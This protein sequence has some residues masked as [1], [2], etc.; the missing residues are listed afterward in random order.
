MLCFAGKV[1][2]IIF[3]MMSLVF[4]YL[5]TIVTLGI[6]L[7]PLTPILTAETFLNN[8]HTTQSS[9]SQHPFLDDSFYIKWSSLKPACIEGDIEAAILL[10][11]K[12]I[13]AI[14]NT[15][16][17]SLTFENTLLALEESMEKLHRAWGLVCHMDSVL[18]GPE[19]REVYN[20]MI[21]RV[22]EFS[23]RVYLNEALWLVIKA[24]SETSE[25]KTL[26]G[27]KKRL[28]DET[29]L[30]FTENGANLSPEK[31]Q[32]LERINSELAMVTQKFSENV[33]DATNS[34]EF[35]TDDKTLLAGLPESAVNMALGLA[36]KKGF[37]TAEKPQWLFNLHMPL[38]I[39]VLQ[40]AASEE[41]REK[42]WRAK[43]GVGYQAPHDN[44]QLV[45]DILKLRQSKAEL[46]GYQNFPDFVLKRRMAKSGQH[47]L[48]FINN[49]HDRVLAKFNEQVEALE[50]YKAKK[51]K[52]PKEHFEPWESMYWF[53]KHRQEFHDFDEEAL[54]P[55]FPMNSVIAGMF[56]ITE[57]LFNIRIEEK[58]A[59]E[60][61]HPDAQYYEVFDREDG[62]LLGGFYTDWYPR[63]SK[64]GG[65]WM[66]H[67]ITGKNGEPHL[68]LMCGNLTPPIGDEPA[69]LSH[70]DVETIFHEF[71]HLLHHL[72][73][74]VA[75]P[76]L[77]GTHVAWD[78][79]E[80][81]SQIMENWAWQRESLDYFARHY[82]TGETIPADL[83]NK[84]IAAKNH[85]S[86]IVTMRQLAFGKIDMEMHLQAIH[87]I[88]AE[89]LDDLISK[90]L[91][92]YTLHYRTERPNSLRSFTHVFGDPTGYASGYYSYKWAEVLE[93]DAFSRFESEGILNPS[94]GKD[95]REAI[96]SKGNS[97]PAEV[98]FH[99]FMGRDPDISA[100]LKKLD[101][102]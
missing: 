94:T 74:K 67:L 68:G 23:T 27:I 13:E 85:C 35:V 18:N 97:E 52:Q 43:N 3:L 19:L 47:A 2:Y 69:L 40:Y 61:W 102:L 46:L 7:Q 58:P 16:K 34:W 96:L 81:P 1:L 70:N 91:K 53:E 51:T 71:G 78:F 31:K 87:F 57:K 93:A 11:Q 24:Y 41:L 98:L 21:P 39:P 4:L 82:K 33:L 6:L 73:G 54:R 17:N 10:A 48:D 72:L 14:A 76:S 9:N 86:A 28:L 26:T 79:V 65:A 75:I 5:I 15:P 20:K 25:A 55:Y 50:D 77:N 37:A 101:L 84:M 64:R 89:K 99:K 30:D 100:L 8:M 66:N 22:S 60:T 45:R 49:F 42:V 83:F 59:V 92:A 56:S 95:F 38:F 88:N 36:I 12:N 80:L 44:T 62:Q 32:E 63:E 90:T 29:I